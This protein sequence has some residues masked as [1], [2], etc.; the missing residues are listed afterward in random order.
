MGREDPGGRTD[1]E[2]GRC[3]SG[4]SRFHVGVCVVTD[5][6]FVSTA[7]GAVWSS[8]SFPY[9]FWTRY[10]ETFAEVRVIAR[11]RTVSA[12]GR[13]DV[14]SDGP[15]VSFAPIPY[16]R[17]PWQYL[18]ERSAVR[19]AVGA[20]LANRDAVILRV[21]SIIANAAWS[22]LVQSRRPYAVEVVG[23]PWDVFAPG[24]LS[25]P[26]RPLLRRYFRRHVARQCA[27]AT[28]AAFVT[29]GVLQ[30]RYPLLSVDRMFAVSDVVLPSPHQPAP[31]RARGG[32]TPWRVVFVGSLEQLY[33]GPDIL[34]QAFA[35]CRRRGLAGTLRLI[36]DGRQRNFLMELASRLGIGDYVEFTGNL[37]A[38]DPVHRELRAADLFV[39]PSRT[40]GL[41]RALIEAMSLG[42]PCLAT[43]VGGI[44]ELLHAEDLLAPGDV[45]SLSREM[46][47]V[48][49]DSR[50][51]ARMRERNLRR[52]GDFTEAVLGP[53]RRAFH[54][55]VRD[56]TV[57]W[58]GRAG[59]GERR[60]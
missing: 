29:Q 46:E 57:A 31:A 45:V 24:T 43:R 19:L 30:R 6:R 53:R 56:A 5:G 22:P 20:A 28:A 38:G 9:A 7:D 26:L 49:S 17:G 25:H 13:Q 21:G 35:A 37:P 4:D 12:P 18:R 44:P 40:E 52:S 39:L 2:A 60:S 36:G 15:N 54:G 32:G 3:P 16:F 48:L 33:K 58:S 27:H 34:L 23:D 51:R 8:S 50:R 11:L 41:P 47:V 1:A 59:Q 10:L 55:L 14:R 42:L